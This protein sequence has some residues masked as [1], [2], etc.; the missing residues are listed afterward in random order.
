MSTT[1]F[2]GSVVLQTNLLT[3]SFTSSITLAKIYTSLPFIIIATLIEQ[4]QGDNVYGFAVKKMLD[5]F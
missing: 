2:A 5:K 3:L 4:L 1:L